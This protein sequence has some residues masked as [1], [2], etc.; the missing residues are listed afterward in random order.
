MAKPILTIG[1]PNHIKMNV[2]KVMNLRKTLKRE[3]KDYYILIYT[4]DIEK[5]E[6]KIL[7]LELIDEKEAKKLEDKIIK[8]YE[9]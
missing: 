2:D 6:I 9:N 5:I 4:D 8:Y 7:S 1:I 3:I